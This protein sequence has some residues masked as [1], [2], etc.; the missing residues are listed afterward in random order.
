MNDSINDIFQLCCNSLSLFQ[1]ISKI[2]IKFTN[3]LNIKIV[4][5]YTYHSFQK[6][7]MVKSIFLVLLDKDAKHYISLI[8]NALLPLLGLIK[9]FFNK[10]G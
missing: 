7:S 10:E 5:T 2:P 9:Y 8:K 3:H 6:H 1:N 4:C